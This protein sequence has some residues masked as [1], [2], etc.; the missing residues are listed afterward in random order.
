[1]TRVITF[2]TEQG[3]RLTSL[4]KSPLIQKMTVLLSIL[5]RQ[6][7]H[8]KKQLDKASHIKQIKTLN[9]ST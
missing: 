3:S 1:M 8:L 5:E 9:H 4:T 7:N 6:H 2:K